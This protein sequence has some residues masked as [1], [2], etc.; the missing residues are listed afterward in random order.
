MTDR[1]L[2]QI[3]ISRYLLSKYME[4]NYVMKYLPVMQSVSKTLISLYAEYITRM[5]TCVFFSLT[6]IQR[7]NKKLYSSVCS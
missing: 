1:G 7:A 6:V 5:L 3:I 4:L 2:V